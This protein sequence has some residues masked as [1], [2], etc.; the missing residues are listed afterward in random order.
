MAVRASA[1]DPPAVLNPPTSPIIAPAT[2]PNGTLPL[3]TTF[4]ISIT[5][6]NPWGETTSIGT[7]SG[8]LVGGNAFSGSVTLPPGATGGRAYYALTGSVNNGFEPQYVSIAANGTFSIVS[9]VGSAG[10]PPQQNSCWNPDTDG[11]FIS[12]A[13]IYKWLNDGLTFIAEAAGGI[14]DTTGVATIAQQIYYSIP[15]RWI[16]FNTARYDQWPVVLGD[17]DYII[18][19]YN[20]NG[21]VSVV[22]AEMQTAANGTVFSSF[23]EPSLTSATTTLTAPMTATSVQL[24]CVDASPFTPMSRIQVD[25]EI[26]LFSQVNA[27]GGPGFVNG[28]IRGAAGTTPAA[29]STGA[30]VQE[31]KWNFSGFRYS[32]LYA[33]GSAL[34]TLDARNTWEVA[35]NEYMLAQVKHKEQSTQEALALMQ[36]F[37]AFAAD[38]RKKQANPITVAQIGGTL[39]QGRDVGRGRII[40][41]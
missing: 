10:Y 30:T 38:L 12:T 19:R 11:G 6:I 3:T 5:A 16:R 40:I 39:T 28:L 29:H 32:Q 9:L 24:S 22:A 34:L 21:V 27:S 13:L 23:P 26:M 35:L 7:A 8:S 31:L 20:V 17:R 25:N 2:L 18:Y 4:Q 15:G 36:H 14:E 37:D 41:Q 1:P 33:P